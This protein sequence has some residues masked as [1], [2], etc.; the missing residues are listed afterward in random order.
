VIGDKPT[1]RNRTQS[2]LGE[3]FWR[4]GCRLRW[5]WLSRLGWDLSTLSL[6]RGHVCKCGRRSRTEREHLSHACDQLP[7]SYDA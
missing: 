7:W 6:T 4:A 2:A 3:F 5:P 1:L